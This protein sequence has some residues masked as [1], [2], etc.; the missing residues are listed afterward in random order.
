[1]I[2]IGR[3]DENLV[4]LLIEGPRSDSPPEVPPRP[5]STQTL[6]PQEPNP[7]DASSTAAS[8]QTTPT[9]L[10]NVRKR[11]SLTEEEPSPSPPKRRKVDDLVKVTSSMMEAAVQHKRWKIVQFFQ[12]KGTVFDFALPVF[13]TGPAELTGDPSRCCAEHEG[14]ANV[15]AERSV[16]LMARSI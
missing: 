13:D 8:Q 10:V 5:S 2:A 4:K 7:R 16:C 6:P 3:G 11:K 1:M 9:T 14:D 15:A 12:E